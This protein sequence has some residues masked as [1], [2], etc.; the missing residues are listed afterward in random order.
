MSKTIILHHAPKLCWLLNMKEKLSTFNSSSKI[1]CLFPRKIKWILFVIRW[2]F[3]KSFLFTIFDQKTLLCKKSA[4][5]VFLTSKAQR[6]FVLKFV[7]CFHWIFETRNVRRVGEGG[8]A[9]RP[10]A[11]TVTRWWEE[12]REGSENIGRSGHKEHD[13]FSK[14]IERRTESSIWVCLA[15]HWWWQCPLSMWSSPPRIL[16]AGTQ[17]RPRHRRISPLP[18]LISDPSH[19]TQVLSLNNIQL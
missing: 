5:L 2:E 17:H 12:R 9:D 11:K 13:S 7:I 6:I 16:E 18:T 4:T 19:V 8:H 1:V 10:G 3:I 14:S 15:S